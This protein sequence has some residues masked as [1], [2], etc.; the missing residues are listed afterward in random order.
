MVARGVGLSFTTSSMI[1]LYDRPGIQFV[2]IIDRPT[3]YTAVAWRPER[4][5]T[6]MRP[7][8]QHMLSRLSPKKS[9]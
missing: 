1:R 8:V 3:S 2:P 9:A 7:L 4:L 6:P 5:S